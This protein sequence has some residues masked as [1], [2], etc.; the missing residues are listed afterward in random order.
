MK[1]KAFFVLLILAFVASW[2]NAAAPAAT[3]AE[4]TGRLGPEAR[5]VQTRKLAA[6][7]ACGPGQTLRIDPIQAQVTISAWDQA[8][9]AVEAIVEVGDSDPEFIKEFLDNVKMTIEPETAGLALRFTSPM[10]WDRRQAGSLGR[11]GQAIRTGRWNLSYAARVEV[12][13][14]AS[15]SLDV[16]NRFGNL[17][18]RGV[19]GRIG[20]RNESGEVRAD[21]CGGE[22]KVQNSFGAVRVVDFKGPADIRSESGE[23]QAENIAGKTDIRNSFKDIHFAKIGGPLTVTSESAGVVGSDVAGDCRITSSFKTIDVRGVQGRLDIAGESLEVTVDNVSRDAAIASGYKPIKVTNVKGGLRVIGNSSAIKAEDIGGEASL[24]SSFQS[25]EAARIHG[26]LTVEGESLAVTIRDAAKDVDIKS[27]FKD[28]LVTGVGGALNVQSQ[29]AKVTATGVK[30]GATIKTSF[31]AVEARNIGRDL[32]IEGESTAVL[33]EDIG[34]AVT[35]RNSFKN[36]TLRGTSGSISVVG[37]SSSVDIDAIKS[38]PAGSVIDIKTSFMPI[39]ITLPAG[40]DFQ[41]TAKTQ[42]GKINTNTPVSLQ[43]AGS[44]NGQT[45]RF[46]SGTGG[47]TLKLETSAD[48]TV[49]KMPAN[50]K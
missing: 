10:D 38:L 26:R 35:V 40:V 14:P 31:S 6:E 17:A 37:E 12:H 27:S 22:L 16:H 11:I 29:S 30:A 7:S 9:I 36:V 34:G 13:V 50:S 46:D 42:F 20:L 44:S 49:K 32:K 8:R 2:T 48:I 28:V 24:K 39:L 47:V 21:G 45:V 5:N 4:R 19:N 15:L 25:I 18:V 3:S 33:A 23:I 1:N 43:N 41:G